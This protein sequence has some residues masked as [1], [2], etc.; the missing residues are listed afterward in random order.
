M[1]N[2]AKDLQRQLSMKQELYALKCERK[3]S[4]MEEMK[5][6]DRQAII[7]IFSILEDGKLFVNKQNVAGN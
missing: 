5:A 6:S 7:D 3:D 4:L 1:L 2:I